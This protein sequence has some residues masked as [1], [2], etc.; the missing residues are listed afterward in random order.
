MTLFSFVYIR[1]LVFVAKLFRNHTQMPPSLMDLYQKE[2]YESREFPNTNVFAYS[3]HFLQVKYTW[4]HLQYVK[5]L[6]WF[7][8]AWFLVISFAILSTDWNWFTHV[9]MIAFAIRS[10]CAVW[11]AGVSRKIVFADYADG[12]IVLRQQW[13]I[14]HQRL[15]EVDEVE[16]LIEQK[17]R[18]VNWSPIPSII[19]VLY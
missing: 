9:L 12:V 4:L 6:M 8:L 16:S 1:L 19:S 14:S 7:R 17:G 3:E 15:Y 10:L 18:A 5:N 2:Y 11:I 13:T